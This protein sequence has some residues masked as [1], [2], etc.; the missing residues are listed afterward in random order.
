MNKLILC[1]GKTDAILLSYYLE[2]TCGWTHR[3]AP[4]T[5][6]VKADESKGESAY[7]YRKGEDS[8]LICGVGG[9]DNFGSF[10]KNKIEPAMIN[11]S[12]FSRMAV[13]TDRDDRQE[14]SIQMSFLTMFR[15]VITDIKNDVW[16][17]NTYY[18][19]FLQQVSVEFLLL[20]IPADQEGAL[21]TLL[22]EAIAEQEYDKN[23][24]Q[25][26]I[27][28]VNEIEPIADRYIGKK[29]LKL[30]ACLGVTWAIQYPEKIFSFI[31]EQIRSVK[32]EKSQI[33]AHCFQNLKQI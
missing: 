24:V 22:L 23:I 31:D 13:V 21:E 27:A 28:Y 33:L 3:N 5:L 14:K 26:S 15:P 19:S 7:W 32:W 12:A 10:Y 29:R 16:V 6:A 18:N 20:I 2:S 17:T 30:K 9:K 1:E 8:L 25:R 11:S 4:K